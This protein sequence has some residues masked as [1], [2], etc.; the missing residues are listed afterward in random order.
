MV[1]EKFLSNIQEY[2]HNL[3]PDRQAIFKAM[4][5]RG[6]RDNFPIIGPVVGHFSYQ[7]ARIA[8]V[9][10]V[11]E[12]GSGYGYSTAWFAKAVQE[13]GGGI[14]HH[15]VWDEG[16]SSDAKKYLADLGYGDIVQFH[17][18]EAVDT[19]AQMDD[20]F[21]IIFL[22]IIKESYPDSLPVI[23]PRLKS[24]GLLLADNVFYGG[25]I[26][27]KSDLGS[28]AKAILEFTRQV[29]EDPEWITT[30]YPVRDGLLV[31]YKR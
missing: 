6:D 9:K 15:V 2:Q 3:V 4:E 28:G 20:T 1:D 16:L 30:I 11:F 21:D 24:G 27:D 31:A 14:V 25:R 19:L 22:D 5:D 8:G 10:S 13:N 18:A 12:L 29:T 7:I 17:V 23:K 26:F